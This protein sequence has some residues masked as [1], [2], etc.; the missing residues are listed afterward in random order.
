MCP[1]TSTQVSRTK[2][3]LIFTFHLAWSIYFTGLN[4]DVWEWHIQGQ[5]FHCKGLETICALANAGFQ[6]T[7]LLYRNAW[8]RPPRVS[9][10][11]DTSS[12]GCSAPGVAGSFTWRNCIYLCSL[13]GL[14]LLICS[15]PSSLQFSFKSSHSL[16][17]LLAFFLEVI[18][19][20]LC[21]W[22]QQESVFLGWEPKH[23]ICTSLSQISSLKG[24]LLSWAI[25]QSIPYSCYPI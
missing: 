5:A 13:S 14:H 21:L 20:Q 24:L 12:S 8:I 19:V 23:R 9:W 6:L 11:E 10:S 7:G 16:F 4:Y 2:L 15:L 25:F 1:V 3:T 22:C 17:L 18:N